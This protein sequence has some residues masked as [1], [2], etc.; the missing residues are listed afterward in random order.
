M[1]WGHKIKQIVL[2]GYAHQLIVKMK[3]R[4]SIV[5]NRHLVFCVDKS[6]VNVQS[7]SLFNNHFNRIIESNSDVLHIMFQL[8]CHTVPEPILQ[9]KRHLNKD[10]IPPTRIQRGQYT[11]M[12]HR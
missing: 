11:D 7:P 2:L 1:L 8:M 4:T 10:I 12:A 3:I 6:N 9:Q 5:I